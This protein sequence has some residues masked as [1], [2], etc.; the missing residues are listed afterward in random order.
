MLNCSV[1][2]GVKIPNP[3]RT[4][5]PPIEKGCEGYGKGTLILRNEAHL[6]LNKVGWPSEPPARTTKPKAREKWGESGDITLITL[7]IQR[8]NTQSHFIY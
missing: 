2:E 1:D 3:V 8:E 7:T 6:H 5:P 4:G